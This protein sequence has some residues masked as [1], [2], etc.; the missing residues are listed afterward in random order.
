L[1]WATA[2]YPLPW[3]VLHYDEGLDGH[4]V[5]VPKIKLKDAPNHP[6]GSDPTW[7]TGLLTRRSTDTTAPSRSGESDRPDDGRRALARPPSRAGGQ[8]LSGGATE[9]ET[10]PRAKTSLLMAFEILNF[11]FML[12]GGSP[13][14]KRAQIPPLAG[15]GFNLPGVETKF[16]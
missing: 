14:T 8:S 7:S 2:C 16:A 15:F 12:L 10:R 9:G 4:V 13:R 5:N 6:T 11:L 1:D 3:S